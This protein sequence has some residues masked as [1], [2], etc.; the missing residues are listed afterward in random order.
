MKT[1]KQFISEQ[2]GLPKIYLDMDGV[3]SDWVGGANKIL[4]KYGYPGWEDSAWNQYD[5]YQRNEIRWAIL[6]KN[7]NLYEFVSFLREGR[8][9]WKFLK[10]YRPYILSTDEG[11][12]EVTEEWTEG[13]KEWL[14]DKLDINK[15]DNVHFINCNKDMFA[16]SK[17]GK[18]NLLID[19]D[20]ECCESFF[21]AGGY[22]IHHV[23]A[24][25]T[26]RELKKLGYK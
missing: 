20:I 23:E 7:P 11:Y 21:N 10:S 18:P 13:R 12:K 4:E 6:R 2:E 24:K 17:E 9:L 15:F 16:I 8:R 22:A 26:I 1:L 5:E 19:D 14:S 3:V 25:A